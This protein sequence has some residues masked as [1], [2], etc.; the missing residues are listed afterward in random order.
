MKK[1]A[2]MIAWIAALLCLAACGGQRAPLTG[3]ET[4]LETAEETGFVGGNVGIANPFVD[5]ATVDEA[6]QAAGV[7]MIAPAS[8]EVYEERRI[9]AVENVFAQVIYLKGDSRIFSRKGAGGEDISG[10][11]NSYTQSK[12]VAVG[13]Y[14]VTMKGDEELVRCA[15]W[16]Y[17]GCTFAVMTDEAMSADAMADLIARV[18]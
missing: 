16:T 6:A 4:G 7:T 13:D 2:V 18:R 1:A 9:Q 10:D 5:Y 14:T 15:V 3:S 12:T 8:V 11:Y 17:G